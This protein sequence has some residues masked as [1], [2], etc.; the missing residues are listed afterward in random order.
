MEYHDENPL[1][2]E[3]T[4]VFVYFNHSNLAI[5]QTPKFNNKIKS[6]E[7]CYYIN[8]INTKFEDN[9]SLIEYQITWSTHWVIGK[10]NIWKVL[11]I[12]LPLSLS[13]SEAEAQSNSIKEM[14][15]PTL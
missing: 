2:P 8:L 13:Q 1:E 10:K 6:S 3:D 5:K 7:L 11:I 15:F 14:Y 4:T 9:P 12:L